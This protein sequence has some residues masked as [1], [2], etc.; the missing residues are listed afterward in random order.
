[1][2]KFHNPFLPTF[3]IIIS[4]FQLSYKSLAILTES[5]EELEM[6]LLH[7]MPFCPTPISYLLTACKQA[8]NLLL[9]TCDALASADIKLH[10][11]RTFIP[12]NQWF[13]AG[14]F[15]ERVDKNYLRPLGGETRLIID[16][17]Q[18]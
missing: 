12:F 14:R 16:C 4:Q 11:R 6:R 2:W 8:V 13:F 9:S 1:M 7:V 15:T 5:L 17:Y 18:V 3:R 10:E